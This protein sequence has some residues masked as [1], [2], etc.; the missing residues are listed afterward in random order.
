MQF[1]F[2]NR[3]PMVS[4]NVESDCDDFGRT[5]LRRG[6]EAMAATMFDI[7]GKEGNT[8]ATNSLIVP[9]VSW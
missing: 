4:D 7:A 3:N 2:R 8:R 6:E 9:T 1:R 5:W